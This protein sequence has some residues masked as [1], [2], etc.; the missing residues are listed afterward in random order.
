MSKRAFDKISAGL[1]EAVTISRGEAQPGTYRVHVPAELNVRA[2]R[3]K[4]GLSQEAFAAR[5]GFPVG[6]VRD[7]EQGRRGPETS[8]RV[9]LTVID[10]EPEAVQRAL[11]G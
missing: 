1:T 11:A 8:A 5:F 9:L 4:L 6:T 3:D 7:W 10:R 2:I